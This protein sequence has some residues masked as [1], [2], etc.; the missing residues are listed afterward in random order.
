MGTYSRDNQ[1][2]LH[3]LRAMPEL[4]KVLALKAEYDAL[5]PA[6]RAAQDAEAWARIRA[7]F[8]RTDAY[9]DQE[10]EG[11]SEQEHEQFDDVPIHELRRAKRLLLPRLR[12]EVVSQTQ[13]Q[14]T[15]KQRPR[16]RR[17]RRT[18]RTS[19]SRGDPSEPDLELEHRWDREVIAAV[20]RRERAK[21]GK[22]YEFKVP[23]GVAK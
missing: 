1:P 4:S 22:G 21:A 3:Q 5:D 8:A 14:A 11:V 23:R 9:I 20:W 10:L 15:A 6:E 17:E 19:G 16:E 18:S 7:T 12:L 13:S 2:D